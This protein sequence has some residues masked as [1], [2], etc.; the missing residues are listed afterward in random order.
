MADET[1][2]LLSVYTP[3][4]TPP[5]PEVLDPIMRELDRVN[6]EMMDAGAWVF[7]GGLAAPS[8]ATVL[9]KTDDD[10]LV[11]DGPFVES[12]EYLGGFTIIKAPDLDAAM[13]WGKKVAAAIGLPIEVRPF[14][15]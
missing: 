3:G 4:G 6:K 9:R 5:P 10:V 15:A 13:D 11:T 12:K 8:T 14:E 1:H 2:Y 7:G